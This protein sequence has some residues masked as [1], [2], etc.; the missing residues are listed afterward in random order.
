[1]IKGLALENENIAEIVLIDIFRKFSMAK[2]PTDESEKKAQLK[3]I[4]KKAIIRTKNC[5]VIAHSLSA[6]TALDFFA[7]HSS[8][9]RGLVLVSPVISLPSAISSI[10]R[11]RLGFFQQYYKLNFL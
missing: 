3:K 10:L 8:K 7:S 9:I 5:V 4:L 6:R 2:S 11:S 1:M